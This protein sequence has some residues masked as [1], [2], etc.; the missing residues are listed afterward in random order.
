MSPKPD[1]H[2]ALTAYRIAIYGLL[3]VLGLVLG[4]IALFWGWLSWRSAQG[5]TRTQSGGF[6]VAAMV[7]GVI[8]LMTNS[9]GLYFVMIGW[10][11]LS[12]P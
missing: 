11:A 6:A 8:E 5:G 9:L 7:L 2:H 4:P 10:Q 1:N 12:A 3:P